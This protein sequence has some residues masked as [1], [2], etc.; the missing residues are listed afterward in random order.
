MGRNPVSYEKRHHDQ[1]TA[2]KSVLVTLDI[3]GK[4]AKRAGVT[5]RGTVTDPG[6]VSYLWG[7]MV[8]LSVGQYRGEPAPG[9]TPPKSPKIKPLKG[10]GDADQK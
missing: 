6:V 7:L 1:A 9:Y 8:W 3:T 5:Y 10:A 4:Y 2:K